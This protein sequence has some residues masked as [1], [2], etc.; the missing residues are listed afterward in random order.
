ML[1]DIDHEYLYDPALD[2]FVDDPTAG[3]PQRLEDW[4][5]PYP[6]ADPLP[7]YLDPTPEP[8]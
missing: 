2:G 8:A 6:D 5:T 7:P 1:A 4:F 3:G